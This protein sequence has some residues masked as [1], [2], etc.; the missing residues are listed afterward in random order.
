MPDKRTHARTHFGCFWIGFM[1][2]DQMSFALFTSWFTMLLF[3]YSFECIIHW[4]LVAFLWVSHEL[5]AF[6][7]GFVRNF[8]TDRLWSAFVWFPIIGPF[9]SHAKCVATNTRQQLT[10]LHL[11]FDRPTEREV[12]WIEF[13]FAFFRICF[14]FYEKCATFSNFQTWRSDQPG[15]KHTHSS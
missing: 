11:N 12:K 6:D 1:H 13:R 9:S 3:G 2:F 15:N 4:F 8:Q 5:T 7:S 10:Q 14:F